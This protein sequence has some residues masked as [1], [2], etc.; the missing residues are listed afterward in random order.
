[1]AAN[2]KETFVEALKAG[3]S[4]AAS[5]LFAPK[6]S[7]AAAAAPAAIPQTPGMLDGLPS[8]ALP[9]AGAAVVALVLLRK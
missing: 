1:M 4:G 8:W 2:V 5:Y 9:A 3:A 6:E 7:T